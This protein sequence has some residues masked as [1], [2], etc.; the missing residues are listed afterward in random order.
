[1]KFINLKEKYVK[2]LTTYRTILFLI[3]IFVI[4]FFFISHYFKRYDCYFAYKEFYD[5]SNMKTYIE[6]EFGN[7]PSVGSANI[8]V[9]IF[10]DPEC[11]F[12]RLFFGDKDIVSFIENRTGKKYIPGISYLLKL[13]EKGKIELYLV[14]FPLNVYGGAIN[15]SSQLYCI[16]KE[17]G[18]KKYIEEHSKVYTNRSYMEDFKKRVSFDCVRKYGKEIKEYE[19]YFFRKYNISATPS[20]LIII[21][22]PDYR[23]YIE[24]Y[25][26]AIKHGG[27][28]FIAE[29]DGDEA[30]IF[31]IKGAIPSDILN[32]IFNP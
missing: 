9:I 15:I 26:F 5:K 21:K 18:L 31:L 1:M 20:L 17:R 11:P 32:R 24:L 4:F 16:Y 2:N 25:K 14:E 19:I 29:V 27:Y 22:N 10:A 28:G 12:T 30:L 3:F 13:L 7:F 23:K 8:S 6:K